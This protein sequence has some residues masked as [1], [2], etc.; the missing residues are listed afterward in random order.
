MGSLGMLV[1][2][3]AVIITGGARGIGLALAEAFA[4]RGNGVAIL[5][6][7]AA[8]AETAAAGLRQSGHNA[9]AYRCDVSDPDEVNKVVAQVADD[10]GGIGFLVNNAGLHSTHYSRSFR[11]VGN[12][13]TR[14]AF[15]VNVHGVI[16]CSLACQ[17]WLAKTQ[18]V[19][20][21]MSSTAGFHNTSPYG[22]TK[23]AVRGLTTAFATEFA[24]DGI[25]VNAVAPG[26]I[27]TET[28][29]KEI[30]QARI[31]ALVQSQLIKRM[32]QEDDVVSMVM[33]ICSDHAS[34]MTGETIKLSGGR[35]LY[36]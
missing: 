2:N 6:I 9:I 8:A 13:D 36:I 26:G 27:A 4:A 23:L 33:F 30:P 32:G 19:V 3:N 28:I 29:L 31:D 34:F 20:V 15:D 12:A 10:F 35:I 18:G 11:D 16:Q 5:D 7:D 21:N 22:V 17:P 1:N 14:K 25:R 24:A